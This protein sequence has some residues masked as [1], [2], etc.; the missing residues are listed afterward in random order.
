MKKDERMQYGT[1]FQP[2]LTL[3]SAMPVVDLMCIP[4]WWYS[5]VITGAAALVLIIGFTGAQVAQ[6]KQKEVRER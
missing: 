1:A 5:R 4:R 6:A 2:V 3:R